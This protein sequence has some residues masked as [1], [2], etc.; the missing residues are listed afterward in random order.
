ML[1]VGDFTDV[2]TWQGFVC[3]AFF[4]GTFADKIV[5]WRVSSSPKTDFVLDALNAVEQALHDRR[6]VHQ[7]G[8]THHSDRGGPYLSI[9]YIERL[10][11]ASIDPSVSSIGGPYDNAL[12][13]TLNG[14]Y[15]AEIIHR[16]GPWKTLPLSHGNP[17]N[18][19]IGSTTVA[20]LHPS[21]TSRHPRLNRGTMHSS[22]H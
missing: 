11:D 18:E 5:G 15:K 14:L 6:P 21:D 3:V 7:G 22:T 4:I 10:A 1:W 9:R 17:S 2:S 8:L 19:S 20:C 13:E 16:L 12:A